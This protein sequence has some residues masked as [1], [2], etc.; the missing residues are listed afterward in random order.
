MGQIDHSRLL[1]T[2]N[3]VLAAEWHLAKNTA[4]SL[5]SIYAN[6]GKKAWWQC[7][8]CDY[9]W[10]AVIASR[11]SAGRGCP[12]C[13]GKIVTLENSLISL[14]PHI[15]ADYDHERNAKAL[16]LV[17]AVSHYK[18]WW[19]CSV[20]SEHSWQAMVMNRVR[21]G[22][23]CPYCSGRYATPENNLAVA[24]PDLAQEFDLVKNAPLTPYDLTPKT[25]KSFGGDV[26][27]IIAIN[28]A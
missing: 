26:L 10:E 19:K 4:L 24:R 1:T 22:D 13:A 7:S 21:Q 27:K 8:T 25:P 23:G 17:T 18:A 14:H 3:P 12:R 20:N 2:V 5:T 11:N 6:S 15:A 28:A 16:E 9:E